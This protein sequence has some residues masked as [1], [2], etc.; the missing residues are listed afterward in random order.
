MKI[1]ATQLVLKMSSSNLSTIFIYKPYFSLSTN[2][3]LASLEPNVAIISSSVGVIE[4][5]IQ[6]CIISAHHVD[7]SV[8]SVDSRVDIIID[9]HTSI[10]NVIVFNCY[11]ITR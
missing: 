7:L 6:I 5:P 3:R 4:R 2:T 11:E 1:W 8:V 10:P 9:P